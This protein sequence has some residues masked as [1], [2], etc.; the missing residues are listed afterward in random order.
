MKGLRGIRIAVML[1][2]RLPLPAPVLAEDEDMAQASWA[3]PLAG[4]LVA[5]LAGLVGLCALAVN[6]P[7]PVAALLAL[8][9]LI[10][11]T[12][13]MHED[14]LADCA[15]GFWGGWDRDRRLKIMRDS[16]V[17]T[18]GALALVVFCLLRWTALSALF[19]AGSVLAPLIAAA[20]VSRAAMVFVMDT[21]PNARDDGLSKSTGRPGKSNTRIAA[22]IAAG[23]TVLL[24]GWTGL[25]VILAA[26]LAGFACARLATAKIGGQTGDVLGMTQQ[27]AEVT[28]LVVLL[29]LA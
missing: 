17:G 2:T 13:A 10:A 29:A 4:L 23:I 18:Y 21:L 26:V 6:I 3:Y 9:T 12:G 22:G 27:V 7:A 14:G 11:T 15:D 19:A 24:L 1:L 16:H 8:A 28:I 25:W 20:L 5:A